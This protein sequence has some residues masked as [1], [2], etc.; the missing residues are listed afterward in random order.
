MAAWKSLCDAAACVSSVDPC[1][2][3]VGLDRA[4]ITRAT[5]PRGDAGHPAVIGTDFLLSIVG[6][7]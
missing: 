6:V 2:L 1:P 7:A 5:N 4:K 3:T